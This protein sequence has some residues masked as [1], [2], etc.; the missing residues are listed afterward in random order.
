[1]P[2]I[3]RHYKKERREYILSPCKQAEQYRQVTDM[4]VPK[5]RIHLKENFTK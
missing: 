2:K 1:M 3:Y 5:A 4:H